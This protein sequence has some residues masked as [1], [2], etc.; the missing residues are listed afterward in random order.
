MENSDIH[1][2]DD[3]QNMTYL[4]LDEDEALIHHCKACQKSS[5]FQGDTKCIYSVDFK[6]YDNSEFINH[7]KYIT[8]DVTLPKIV[9][10]GNI[11]CTNTECASVKGGKESSVTY[12]KYDLENMRY[13]YICDHCGQKWKNN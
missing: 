7:N 12:I 3:C 9:N 2:C 5:P 11:K 6:E 4:Y 13:I 8:H 1:F 10:N